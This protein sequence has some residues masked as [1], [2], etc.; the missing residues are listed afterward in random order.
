[1]TAA[2]SKAWFWLAG[3]TSSIRLASARGGAR[4]AARAARP[5]AAAGS[6]GSRARRRCSLLVLGEQVAAAGDLAVH[7]R[8]AHLLERDLLADHH[9][10]HARR[11]EVHRRVLLDHEDDV[12]ERRDVGAARR[13]RAEQQADLRHGAGELDLVVEDA[14]GVAPPREHVDLIGDA[15]ARRVDQVEERDAQPRRRL[16]DAHDLLDGARAPRAG[17]HRRVVGHDRD[18]APVHA[19]DAR[20]DAVGGQIARRVALAKSPSSTKSLA[21]SSQSSAMRSRPKSLPGCGV[22]LVVL[23][24]AALL[25]LLG[26]RLEL[27]AA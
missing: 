27:V 26:E 10:G 14:P 11:A 20:D 13:R 19:P 25:D 8:A 15:R 22:R 18:R 3:R 6:R 5:P 2:M 21:P 4:R 9:L 23:G 12:A 1:M 24:R 7:A 16:L 17:L